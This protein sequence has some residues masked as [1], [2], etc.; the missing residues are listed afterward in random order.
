ML[1]WY[2]VLSVSSVYQCLSNFANGTLL[3]VVQGD[4]TENKIFWILFLKAL[5]LE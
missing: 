3:R 2:T 5:S 1:D 4:E